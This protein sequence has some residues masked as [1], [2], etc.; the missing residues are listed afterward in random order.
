[1]AGN[2]ATAPPLKAFCPS[3]DNRKSKNN[4]KALGFSCLG[5]QNKTIGRCDN[6]QSP[7]LRA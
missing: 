7:L 1:L 2:F 6:T 5:S 3:L 4:L